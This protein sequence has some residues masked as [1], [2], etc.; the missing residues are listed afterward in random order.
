MDAKGYAISKIFACG[1][2][3]KNE[4]FLR[5]HASVTGCELVLPKEP[6]A[7]LLGAAVLGAVASGAFSDILDAMKSM[8]AGANRVLP[9][10]GSVAEF[11]NRK[12]KVFR[13]MHDDQIS[14]R[15]LMAGA[16]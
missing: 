14:Y 13:R 15:R 12:Y 10:G 5:E 4:V 1:G 9:E 16:K 8:N 7:V 6:E 2:G 11:H 3:L